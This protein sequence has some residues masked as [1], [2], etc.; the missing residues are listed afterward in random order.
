[1]TGEST[2]SALV[3]AIAETGIDPAAWAIGWARVLPSVLLVPAFGL[4]MLPTSLRAAVGLGLS[5]AIA[6]AMPSGAVHAGTA[7]P[8]LVATEM[9][10][11]V[12]VAIVAATSIWAAAT[13]GGVVEAAFGV[14]LRALTASFGRDASPVGTL[15]GLLACVLFLEN[16]G[17]T[18]L[19][20]QLAA[21]GPLERAPFAAAAR[22]L[23]T[24]LDVGASLGAPL[25][26][27]ALVVDVAV[28]LSARELRTLGAEVGG[29]L[30]AIAVLVAS[31]VLF[32]R[33]AEAIALAAGAG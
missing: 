24:G 31:A 20:A 12:P 10:R 13:A 25:L 26:V 3:A 30:R 27:V 15:F 14:R 22:D 33:I 7:L 19:A 5:A 4:G 29:S 11:G 2:L 21:I 17:A 1:V 16:G 23:A 6:S 32:D 28:G 9:L 8:L 18:R